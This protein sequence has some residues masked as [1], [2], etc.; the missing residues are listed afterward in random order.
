M[1][2]DSGV[3]L[4]DTADMYSD[5]E[6]EEILGQAILSRRDRVLLAT[7]AR[8]PVGRDRTRQASPGTT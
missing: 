4:F 7:K 2:L 5:G 8:M 1:C 3:N 6:S